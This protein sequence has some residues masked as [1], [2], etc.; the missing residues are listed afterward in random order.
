M[1]GHN[2]RGFGRLG[3][4]TRL[5]VA[6]AVLAGGGAASVVAV[7]ASHSDAASVQS[8]GYSTV[9]FR[10]TISEPTALTTAISGWPK[11]PGMT[12]KTLT[13]LAQMVPMRTFSQVKHQGVMLAAQR[14]TV[15]L[16]AKKFLVVRSANHALHAWL[17]SGGTKF[18]NVGR[19][20]TGLAAMTGGTMAAPGRMATKVKG[21]AKGDL[22]FIVGVNEHGSLVAK[23]VL[24]AAPVKVEPTPT[25][26]P[27]TTAAPSMTAAPSVT[28]TPAVTSTEP[29]FSGRNS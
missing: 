11:S 7:A 18:I 13:A 17:V 10:H 24:F 23:L 9:S 16:A 19:S 8:A 3:M 22:V 1:T 26:T 6:A 5:A 2:K 29:T 25:A 20:R 15:T 14:G 21:V 28:A 4:R 12:G 27:S